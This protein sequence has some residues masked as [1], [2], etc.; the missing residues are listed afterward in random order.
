[1]RDVRAAE[2]CALTRTSA[3][4]SRQTHVNERNPASFPVFSPLDGIRLKPEFWVQQQAGDVLI[5][6]GH[7]Y[8]AGQMF[9]ES[10]VR[11]LL[12]EI[13]ADA[14]SSGSRGNDDVSDSA[15]AASFPAVEIG[16]G[17]DLAVESERRAID[18][19]NCDGANGNSAF[20]NKKNSSSS[21][22]GKPQT[23]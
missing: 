6:A 15:T 11:H 23:R 7:G 3:C 13:A 18:S 22:C 20:G 4:I 17:G 2:D 8:L 19:C 9:R 21:L 1:M 5:E 10:K 14:A 12:D 16:E